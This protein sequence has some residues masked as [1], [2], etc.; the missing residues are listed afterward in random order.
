MLLTVPEIL[1]WAGQV[2]WQIKQQIYSK[3]YFHLKNQDMVKHVKV[4]SKTHVAVF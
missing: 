4:I 2:G 1:Q 3:L